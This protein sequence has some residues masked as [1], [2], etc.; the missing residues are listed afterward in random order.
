M[1]SGNLL[2]GKFDL[3]FDL[4]NQ[5]FSS[6]STDALPGSLSFPVT[7]PLTGRNRV[8]LDFPEL[9]NRADA[10]RAAARNSLTKWIPA[11]GPAASKDIDEVWVEL[12][13]VKMFL[14]SLKIISATA[15]EAS[16]SV[17]A[18]PMRK[19]KERKIAELDLGGDRTFGAD[20][21]AKKAT[22]KNSALEPEEHD[23]VFFPVVGTLPN[24]NQL[25][26][27]TDETKF[28][29]YYDRTLEA[30]DLASLAITPYVKL[31]YVLERLFA[32]EETGY[33]FQNAWQ[34]SPETKRYYLYNNRDLRESVNNA[35]PALPEEFDLARFVPDVKATDLLKAVMAQFNLVLSTNIFSRTIRLVPVDELL[36]RPPARDWSRYAVGKPKTEPAT[37]GPGVFNY[38]QPS[39]PPT[40]WPAPHAAIQYK[41]G[42]EYYANT[43]DVADLGKFFYVE[44]TGR[45]FR[46][47]AFISGPNLRKHD[48]Y[49]QHQGVYL[50]SPEV[51]QVSMEAAGSYSVWYYCAHDISKYAEVDD[52]GIDVWKFQPV[53]YPLALM[54]YRGFQEV[55]SGMGEEP[56]AANYVWMPGTSPATRS[57][58]VTNGSPEGD[59]EHSL[60]WF[61][62]Y[63]LYERRHK[64]W[65]TMLREGKHVTQ[66]LALP[67]ADLVAFSFEEKIR[68]A[69][70]DYFVKKLRVS[71]PL[72]RGRVLVE[73]GLVSVM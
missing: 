59:S 2:E 16:I 5:L 47:V 58:V 45:L 64:A 17:I 35:A 26:D 41:T 25:I 13:G 38:Q 19:L 15:T 24:V 65:N 1:P 71:R 37:G 57:Q 14:G 39:A 63:G 27:P 50:D 40:D 4:V 51:Y 3:G 8:E 55:N 32:S 23:F 33:G 6:G 29:N 36:S 34:T 70:M 66:Q 54:Q 67:V 62:E 28:H 53:A 31:Q 56:F 69:S 42:A 43:D 12:Y 48:G 9:V 52:G 10:S 73:A 44:D 20:D 61:G 68:I 49:I 22:M 46:Y 11:T 7:V 21:A 18:N 72:G 60:N 30:F